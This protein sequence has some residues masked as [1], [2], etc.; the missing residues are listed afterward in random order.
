[1]QNFSLQCGP[2]Y[3]LGSWFEQIP[4]DTFIQV[5]PLLANWILRRIS[6]ISFLYAPMKKTDTTL[7]LSAF[8]AIWGD[9]GKIPTNFQYQYFLVISPWKIVWSYISKNINPLHLIIF[10]LSLVE[11]GSGECQKFEDG[12]TNRQTHRQMDKET[13]RQADR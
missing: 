7:K 9:F 13:S 3:S 11:T 8:L 2:P 4:K 12:L 1:M 5:T 10:V 6:K